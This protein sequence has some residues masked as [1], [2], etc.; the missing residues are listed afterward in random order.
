[1]GESNIDWEAAANHWLVKEPEEVRMPEEDLR[2]EILKFLDNHKVCALATAGDG[3]VRNT[4]VEYLYGDGAFWIFSEGGLKF[5]A[6]RANPNVCLAISGDDPS[7]GSLAG[8]Q[9]TATAEVVAPFGKEYEHACAL[10]GL[11]MERLQQ[12]PFV[13]NVI[14]VT[15]TRFDYLCSALKDQSYSSRQHLDC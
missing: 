10:R 14:K 15:P 5:K 11:P 13:M 12:L 2:V 9:V 1:M 8:L 7:F 4:P 6:L 3:I